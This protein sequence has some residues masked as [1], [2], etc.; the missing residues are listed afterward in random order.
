[1]FLFFKE[2]NSITFIPYPFL[3][4]IVE[5]KSLESI[6]WST[7]LVCNFILHNLYVSSIFS[8]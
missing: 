4:S 2:K 3:R 8:S 7:D 5:L 1:M 6:E